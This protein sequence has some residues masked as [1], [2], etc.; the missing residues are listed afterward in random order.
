M[1]H[2]DDSQRFATIVEELGQHSDALKKQIAELR[3][4]V[5]DGELSTSNGISLL[6]VKY[7][8]LLQYITQL[9]YVIGRKLHGE[10]LENS[11]AIDALIHDR[12]ILEK[13]KPIEQKLKYQLDK[14]IRAASL[15]ASAGGNEQVNPYSFKPN[16]QQLVGANDDNDAEKGQGNILTINR[17][18]KL[19]K[20]IVLGGDN[21]TD[22]EGSKLY[23]APRLA[24]VHYDEGAD[25]KEK[26]KKH[27]QRLLEKAAKSRLIQDLVAE[28]DDRPE[29]MGV[30]GGA[31]DGYGGDDALEKREKE[32]TRYEEDNFTRLSLSKQETRRMR[33]GGLHRFTNE[34]KNLNDFSNLAGINAVEQ[35]DRQR[36]NLLGR[37][38]RRH[39]ERA[40]MEKMGAR[41]RKG[42]VEA[43]VEDDRIGSGSGAF[44]RSRKNESRRKRRK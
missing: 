27:E 39:E 12:I 7:H 38:E 40:N 6:E 42:G 20:A 11:A 24:P 35:D 19:I 17:G 23:R 13:V 36:H 18:N 10:P 44:Q 4:R 22:D 3:K 28:Y 34:F 25:A 32:R 21:D 1:I 31:R 14:L 29:Q 2:L 15:G 16:P 37:K 33:D 9:V 41:K 5:L 8:T 43:V 26:R 30:E